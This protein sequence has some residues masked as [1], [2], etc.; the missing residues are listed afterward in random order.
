MPFHLAYNDSF[1][2]NFR[3]CGICGTKVLIYRFACD[4]PIGSVTSEDGVGVPI[5]VVQLEGLW[6]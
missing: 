2:G 1:N 3:E 6:R 5:S 4:T